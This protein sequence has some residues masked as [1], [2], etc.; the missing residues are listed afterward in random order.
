MKII[1]IKVEFSMLSSGIFVQPL[2]DGYHF[3]AWEF[4][5]QETLK[6]RFL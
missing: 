1:K 4:L 2:H 6:S 5:F 3:K